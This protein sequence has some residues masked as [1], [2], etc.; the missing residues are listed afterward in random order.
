MDAWEVAKGDDVAGGA[1]P[2]DVPFSGDGGGGGCADGEGV[3][4]LEGAAEVASEVGADVGRAAAE[5]FWDAD[6]AADGDVAAE[7]ADAAAEVEGFPGVEGVGF[8]G[9]LAAPADPCG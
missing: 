4:G 9:G 8:P 1:G 3:S 5:D 2:G 6:A 7:V